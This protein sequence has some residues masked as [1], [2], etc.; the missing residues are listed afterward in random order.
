MLASP[1]SDGARLA[2]EFGGGLLEKAQLDKEL[3]QKEKRML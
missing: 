1:Y 2:C 3:R